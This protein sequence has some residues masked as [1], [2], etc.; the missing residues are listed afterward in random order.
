MSSAKRFV[1]RQM[2]MHER[3]AI[4]CIQETKCSHWNAHMINSLGLGS[5]IGWEHSPARGQS[6]GLLTFWNPLLVEV[7][8]KSHTAN[9]LLITG[10]CKV[11]GSDF[12]CINI[13]APQKLRDKQSMWEELLHVISHYNVS[14]IMLIGDF[15][16]VRD[17]NE[18]ENCHFNK[19][20]SQCFNDFILSSLLMDV[21]LSNSTF[22]WYGH[23]NKRSRLDRSLISVDW[24]NSGSWVLKA[25]HRKSSDHKPICLTNI[26]LNWG[27]K[28]FRFFN[29]W[30]EDKDFL[31]LLSTKWSQNY[32]SSLSSKLKSLKSAAAGWNKSVFGNID[33]KIKEAEAEQ[34]KRDATK[35][36]VDNISDKIGLDKLYAIKSSMLCQ[37]SRL[38]WLLKGERNTK[39]FHSTIARRRAQNNIRRIKWG[40]SFT[41]NPAEIKGIFFDYF[42]SFLSDA[43]YEKIFSLNDSDL[44]RLPLNKSNALQTIFT[45]QEVEDALADTDKTKA[46][47][48][49]GL[50]AGVLTAIW[51]TIKLEVMDF[52]RTFHDSGKIPSGF[53][54][55]FIALIPKSMNASTPA[56]YRPI[57]L[58]NALIK[59]LSKVLSKRLKC[60]MPFL[61]SPYQSAFIRGRQISDS[62][63]L[64]SEVV[65][66]LKLKKTTGLVLKIDFEKAFDRIQWSF[67]Y[68]VLANMN[69]GNIW[70]SWIRNI[71]ES[72]RI[73]VLVNG[74]PT[75]E[76]S[77]KRGLRQGDP[78]SPLLFNLVGEVFSNFIQRAS[79]L[80]L[81]HGIKLPN[82]NSRL[83]HLQFAD[84]VLLFVDGNEDA[85]RGVKKVLQCFQL[86]TGMKVNFNKSTLH[87]YSQDDPTLHAW[88]GILG[89]RVGNFSFKY[90][91]A[92]LGSSPKSISYWD[93]LIAKVQSRV[94]SMEVGNISLAGRVVLL[95]SVLDSL[96]TYWFNL[97]KL[98]SAVLKNL[99]GIRRRFFWG[100]STGST[101][102]IHF[103]KWEKICQSKKY[104]GLG[105]SSV[106]NRNLILLGKWWWRAYG[107]RQGYWNEI[108]SQR[109]GLNW[110]LDLTKI[111]DKSCSPVVSSII[112]LKKDR[113][114]Q[115]IT[116]S[117]NYRWILNDG[118]QVLFWED[119]WY[120]DKTLAESHPNLYNISSFKQVTVS[121]LINVNLDSRVLNVMRAQVSTPEGLAE[122][123]SISHLLNSVRLS[124]KSD[125]LVWKPSGGTFSTKL[126]YKLLFSA[127]LP[128]SN[129]FR[130]NLV[131]GQIVPPKIKIFLWKVMWTILPTKL[132]LSKRLSNI[133]PLCDW[134]GVKE[135]TME[136]IF[137]GC[138]VADWMWQYLGSWWSI[139]SL[140]NRHFDFSLP[141]LFLLTRRK[142]IKKVWGLVVAAALWTIW[143]ARNDNVFNKIRATKKTVIHL[144]NFRISQWGEAAKLLDFGNDPL[145][146]VNPIGALSLRHFNSS[147]K[148]W[149][150]KQE[151]Y[152][153][154]CMVDG[155]W[156]LGNSGFMQGGIGGC[157]KAKSGKILYIFSGPVQVFNAD[158]AELSAVISV[159]H[160]LLEKNLHRSHVVICTD[161]SKVINALYNGLSNYFPLLVPNFDVEALLNGM[162][163]VQYVPG[164]INDIADQLARDGINRPS[165]FS[166]WAGE[167]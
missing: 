57:S 45:L 85:I 15:N 88:A 36:H 69:F 154:V 137:W 24:F 135:E 134:C 2:V 42:R 66:S 70:I 40:D 71:F 38:N 26:K 84:D 43:G 131:W 91:G 119:L 68:E 114:C 53:N 143:L 162:V 146:V 104:G 80:G 89:C 97:F 86:L 52:F 127:D 82:V 126:S 20:E 12:V 29:C 155:A 112:S 54:S 32:N 37:K 74:S 60:H 120:H 166:Y 101:K 141:R 34:E 118:K 157:I 98:P 105:L 83:T 17:S 107:E 48:P 160:F 121:E 87:G 13:Y 158:E 128:S 144:L 90:L 64:A 39:L 111:I 50:N 44:H 49:D 103:L 58:M 78:L 110:R 96:P 133:N 140:L 156:S 61:V 117:S 47:G 31:K 165:L 149:D 130:W 115:F 138:E 33:K 59:L 28:P 167:A 150:F 81:F 62:I 139:P 65:S 102:K 132:V 161:S 16:A 67:V 136:H 51:P 124:N 9:W 18:K 148:F 30:L 122:F 79:K 5:N 35:I 100:Y 145:W 163:S 63:L 25:L 41:S 1:L 19:F 11:D 151:N 159:L 108:L 95:N 10:K 142:F 72:S 164:D 113:S 99:E 75:G 3:P 22:T 7:T 109:Y 6:G 94:K 147:R 27:P 21:S 4:I 125:I 46:P 77:P 14:N 123:N 106:K 116:D 152:D 153:F 56:D 55:S 23:S 8:D 76:F 73:S 93:P 92:T 129:H